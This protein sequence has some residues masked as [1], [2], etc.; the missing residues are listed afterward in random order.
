MH[1]SIEKEM[2]AHFKYLMD[3]QK[4]KEIQNLHCCFLTQALGL[5]GISAYNIEKIYS[6]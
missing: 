6:L 1:L 3:I 4:Q 5:K 2:L